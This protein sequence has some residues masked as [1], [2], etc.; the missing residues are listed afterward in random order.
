MRA[1]IRCSGTS[2]PQFRNLS[3]RTSIR[4]RVLCKNM[5]CLY[6][7]ILYRAPVYSSL[8]RI[9]P[10]QIAPCPEI[11]PVFWACIVAQFGDLAQ[12]AVSDRSLLNV[13]KRRFKG[14][15]ICLSDE[16]GSECESELSNSL[17]HNIISDSLPEGSKCG[18]SLGTVEAIRIDSECENIVVGYSRGVAIHYS[19]AGLENIT[20]KSLKY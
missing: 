4:H 15:I 5:I 19:L 8:S 1:S 6:F 3:K 9:A 14:D 18:K 13:L 17:N 11:I 2:G 10:P 12:K 20:S 16:N 7:G